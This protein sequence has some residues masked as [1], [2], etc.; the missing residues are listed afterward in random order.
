M[1]AALIKKQLFEINRSFFV[2]AKTGKKR[3]QAASVTLIVLYAILMVFIIGGMFTV[4]AIGICKPLTDAGMGW[5]YF[6][7]FR[8]IAIAM[9]VFGSVF[10]TY[11]G[12]YLAKDNDLLLSLPI[13][14][15]K[16]LISRLLGVYIMGFMFSEVVMIPAIIVYVFVAPFGFLTA[17]G[18]LT[19]FL[20][21]PMEVLA[22]SC[23][24]GW[25]TA[26]ISVKLKN[27][28]FITV[29]I[30]LVAFAAYYF[31]YFQ[32][33]R[34]ITM[35]IENIGAV[36]NA[37]LKYAY[38]LYVI[39]SSGTGNITSVLSVVLMTA[40]ICAIVYI[41]LARSFIKIATSSGTTAGIKEKKGSGMREAS[42]FGALLGKEF[43]RFAASP[44]YIL[45]CGLG[46]VF[47]AAAAIF[48]AVKGGT[49]AEITA[50]NFPGINILPAL[51][52]TAV[53]L[54][55]TMNDTAAA[56]VSL[57]GK[58]IWVL[59]SLPVDCRQVLRAKL[60][61]Q[62]ILTAPPAAI[63]AAAAGIFMR[64]G[65]L[66]TLLVLLS[67]ESFVFLSAYFGLYM[68][69]RHP[70][71]TWQNEVTPIKQSF[72]VFAALF[73]GW[74]YVIVSAVVLFLLSIVTVPAVGLAV[75]TAVNAGFSLALRHLI[76]T[77]G[78]AIFA[79]L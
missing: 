1:L 71:L 78:C 68:N 4:L 13:P 52:A 31:L 3:S 33:N 70:N 44:A 35:L 42:P 47:L 55:A 16:L 32:A 17:V 10:N 37:V 26:K 69:L 50:E 77:K 63:C 5:M 36:G 43:R 14:V 46:T 19:T 76:N 62:V 61:V 74:I 73:G 66:E 57:E 22:L 49:I 9:G 75:M 45:N 41:V 58:N 23:I 59:Q 38:P 20:T 15:G 8:I 67:A 34:L 21:V 30:S 18:L 56:S 6:A 25:V 65:V 39:G 24:F 28:S 27:R 72:S 64:L 51:A 12:L 29:I 40:G 11:A 54:L 2:N 53:C 60:F 7:M 79:K 48:V